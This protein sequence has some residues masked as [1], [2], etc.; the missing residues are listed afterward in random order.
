MTAAPAYTNGKPAPPP[1]RTCTYAEALREALDQALAGDPRVYLMGLGVPDPK[2]VFG[3]TLGLQA[4]HGSRRVLDMP[5]AENAMT[6]I[7]IGS[8]L[9]G[10]R[11]VMVH[12]RADFALLALDQLVNNAAKWHYMFGGKQSVPIVVRLI[13][14]RGWG[15]GPQ[16]SQ[17]LQALFAHIP[18]LKVVA[19][20]TP[21]DAKGMLLAAIEDDDPVI[22]FEHRW[23]HATYGAVPAERYTVPLGRAQVARE[24]SD[25]TLI[26]SSY[27]LLETLRA[28]EALAGHDVDAEV[29]DVRTLRPLDRGCLLASA[30][31]TGRA[32]VV[33]GGWRSFGVAAEIVALLAENA[34]DALRCAPRRVTFPDAYTPTTPALSKYYYP[35]AAQI[36]DTARAMLG[37]EPLGEDAYGLQSDRPL[38]V[39]DPSFRGPF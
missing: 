29:I 17:A 5:T 1:V 11:P 25:V 30:G 28:A 35:T 4:K 21:H 14:G 39:P 18:G 9:V 37:L 22:F 33:D 12:Q 34:F 38:D 36:A 16:H 7:A 32:L 8:A 2:G 23:L 31:K 13:V 3:T 19:P 27:F 20:A 15:Q 6:G 24:G 26:S 10:M